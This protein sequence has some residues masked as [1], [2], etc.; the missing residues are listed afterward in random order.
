MLITDEEGRIVSTATYGTPSP[1]PPTPP[2]VGSDAS[3]PGISIE[4]GGIVHKA[5]NDLFLVPGELVVVGASSWTEIRNYC[6]TCHASALFLASNP[7]GNGVADV[8]VVETQH[9]GEMRSVEL[10]IIAR[11]PSPRTSADFQGRIPGTYPLSSDSPSLLPL[12]PRH[13]PIDIPQSTWCKRRESALG[14]DGVPPLN[15]SHSG[16]THGNHLDYATED[17]DKHG[18][19]LTF[20]TM[21]PTTIR[22][23]VKR[24][25]EMNVLVP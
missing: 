9:A 20:T 17:G 6:D 1:W 18:T 2:R 25:E 23:L 11:T 8:L 14:L 10:R 12:I 4:Q 21:L 7:Y 3:S 15:T 24:A 16:L 19:A 13:S 5:S 22:D